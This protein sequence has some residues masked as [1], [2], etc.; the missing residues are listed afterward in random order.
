MTCDRCGKRTISAT[1]SYFN[2]ETICDECDARERAHPKFEEARRIENE[3]VRGGDYNFPGVGL[4][5]DLKR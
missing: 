2:T 5:D 3:A 1:M 4:P